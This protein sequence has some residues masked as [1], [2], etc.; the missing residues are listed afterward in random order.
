M[1]KKELDLG[2]QYLRGAAVLFVVFFHL[3]SILS[4]TVPG[5]NLGDMLFG[6]GSAGVDVFF[7][8]SGYIIALSTQ[9]TANA[10][11]KSFFIKRFFR[12]YP[13]FIFCLA[14]FLIVKNHFGEVYSLGQMVRSATM[15]HIDY[16]SEAPYF[17]YNILYPAWTL[18]YEVYFYFIFLLALLVSH[19]HRI[20]IAT[21]L[22]L[23]PTII[24][25]IY[26]NGSVSLR[27]HGVGPYGSSI[28]NMIVSPMFFEFAAGM[29]LYVIRNSMP[30]SDFWKYIYISIAVISAFGIFSAVNAGHGIDGY[31]VWALCV[32]SSI[33]FIERCSPLPKINSLFLLGEVSYS[34]YLSHVI[35]IAIALDYMLSLGY[36][37]FPLLIMMTCACVLFSMFMYRFIEKKSIDFGRRLII[38]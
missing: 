29:W 30:K 6:E 38:N 5:I 2:I 24:T 10:S 34:I 14:A 23:L 1:N 27:A 25:Q 21:A 13:P 32:V 15:L 22:I 4:T 17:G 8:I 12:I 31:G 28:L 35:I 37:G 20:T 11:P 36:K 33:V 26:F 16:A 18:A 3:R 9:S 19:K 7:V